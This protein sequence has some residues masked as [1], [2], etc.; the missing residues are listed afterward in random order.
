MPEVRTLGAGTER[1]RTLVVG[2]GG[3]G[4]NTLRALPESEGLDRLA[5]NDLPHLSMAGVRRRLFV[6]K[7]G[8]REVAALDLRTVR[9]L[10]TTAEQAVAVELGDAD[11]VVPLA[12]LGGDV[13]SWGASLVARVAVLKGALSFAVVTTPFSAEGLARKG[14]AADALESLRAHAHGVL[15]LANDGLL[16]VA[17]HLPIL[18]AFEVLSRIACQPVLDLLRVLTRENI[19]ILKAVFRGARE[20][21]LG[22]GEGGRDHP[23][24]GAVESAFRSPWI[25]R[26]PREAREVLVLLASPERDDGL[27]KRILYDVDLRAPKA[28]VTSG[29]FAEPGEGMRATVLVGF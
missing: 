19:P 7:A 27:V 20:W 21:Q 24:L 22:I 18:R 26:D 12:G 28:S 4:C 6:Q 3:A 2:C 16:R 10:A 15:A 14:V 8:L 29:T 1:P 9:S 25:T 23:E 17:P 13:G 5:L 11:V